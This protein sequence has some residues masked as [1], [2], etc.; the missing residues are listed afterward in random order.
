LYT[1]TADFDGEDTFTYTVED[2]TG[3]QATGTVTV[4]VL[5]LDSDRAEAVLTVNVTGVND[6]PVLG[7][8][9]GV[10]TTDKLSVAPFTKVTLSDK[11]KERSTFSESDLTDDSGVTDQIQTVTITYDSDLGAI[12]TVGLSYVA[13]GVYRVQGTPDYVVSVLRAIVFTPTENVRPPI[14]Y[15]VDIELSITDGDLAEPIKDVTTVTVLG[16][17]DAPVP[18]ADAYATEENYPIRIL[19]DAQLTSGGFNFG[20]LPG[21]FQSV[22]ANGAFVTRTPLTQT[23]SLLAND[24][25]VDVD[26]DAVVTD[27]DIVKTLEVINVHT[28]AA[29]VD[30]ITAVSALGASIKLDIRAAREETNILYDPRG[31]AILNALRAGEKV[32]D[33]FYYTVRDKHGAFGTAKVA[34]EVTGVNDVP[35]ANEDGGF[36]TGEDSSITILGSGV[37]ANDTDPDIDGER[38]DDDP[39]IVDDFPK[40]SNLGAN[41]TFEGGNITYDPSGVAV[42]EA[43]ARNEFIE[44]FITYTITDGEGGTSTST[45]SLEVEGFNDRPIAENDLLEIDENDTQSRIRATGLISNDTEIDID[46][47]VPDDDHWIIP[48]REVTTP[49]GAA[50]DVETDGSYTYDANSMFIESMIEGEVQVETFPYIVIDNFRTSS[51]P[52]SFKVLADSTDVLLP[53]LSNDDVAGSVPVA[54]LG[55]TEDLGD[56]GR[57]IIES[58]NHALRDGLLIKIQAYSGSGAYNG[59]FPITV[60]DVDHFS[61]ETPFVDDPA[62]TRGTW[63]P[64]FNITA[65][66]ETDQ[67]GVLTID[68]DAQAVLY[69]PKAGFSGTETFEYTIEDGVG[70]QDVTEVSILVLDAPLNTVL[71][72]SDDRFQIGTGES[73]VE[74]DVLA[75]DNTRPALGTQLTITEVSVGSAGGVLAIIDAG[76]ALTYTPS[77][78]SYAGTET[79]TY[80]V[81]GGGSSTTTASISIEVIDRLD[82]L[83]GSDDNFFVV[84]DSTDN[85]LD[86]AANDASL[87]SFPVSF[88][89]VSVT[90]LSNGGSATI[91]NGKVNYSPAISF[92][93]NETFDYTIRDASGGYT[94][95]TVSVQVVP[96]GDDFYAQNDQY[97]VLAG[98]PELNL[99]VLFND[100]ATGAINPADLD[101]YE[102][103]LDTQAPPEVSRVSF[104]DTA[105][106]YTAPDALV[107]PGTP[108]VEIFNYEI[109]DGTDQRREATITIVIVDEL[110][111]KPNA[112]DDNFHVEKNATNID[113]DVLL[114]DIPLPNAAWVWTI[115]SVGATDQG[116]T[117]VNNGGTS[118]TYSPAH[119]F[120]G[121]ESFD[122]TIIDAFG[123]TSTATVT[124]EVGEQL[125]EPD[126]YVVLENSAD[127]DFPVLVNDD[128]LERFPADYTISAA[129]TVDAGFTPDTRSDQGGVITQLA[130]GPNNQIFYTPPA[131]FVG[132]D[133]FTYTVIDNT[134]ATL[135]ETVT[136]EVIAEE[137]DRDFAN[138]RV[139]ITGV[140]DIPVLANVSNGATT[141]KE[142]VKPFPTVSITDVDGATTTVD[143]ADYGVQEQTVTMTY[144]TYYGTV[145]T[146]GMTQIGVGTY[147]VVGTPAEVTAVLQD[148]VFTPYENL[149][150]YIDPGVDSVDFNLSI[151]D[152]Y[153]VTPV[154]GTAT[155]TITPIDDGPTLVAELPDMKLQVNDLA[156]AVH[157]PPYFADV[158]DDVPGGQLT[159]S[160]SGNT[161]AGLFDS[162]TTDQDKQLLVIVLAEDAFGVADITVRGTDRG[163]LYVE[164]TF[165]LT[166]DGPPVI[167]LPEGQNQPLAASYISGSQSGFTRDYRQSFR[168][169]NEGLLPAQA[170]VLH[171]TELDQPVSGIQLIQAQYSS[172]ENG[173]QNNFGDDTR[174]SNGV[175]VLQP[176]TYYYTVKYDLPLEPGESVVVH[177]RYRATSVEFINIRPN[178][179]VEL[180]T[181]SPTLPLGT[182]AI[183]IDPNTGDRQITVSLEAGVEYRLEYS[184]DLVSWTP[185]ATALPVGEFDREFTVVDDGLNTDT[186]PSLVPLRFYRLVELTPPD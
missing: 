81:S 107:T 20:D 93:G 12:S 62:G 22:D 30:Q 74:I 98:S 68:T 3:S 44:D 10:S 40:T 91:V 6:A 142:S 101:I 157:L 50:L 168:V 75:N 127:N 89:I 87:P 56:A 23:V 99:P 145:A 104:T 132:V 131:D 126:Y 141:D 123:A 7:G 25:D 55:Y 52:D 70:G 48:Q 125:T 139:E 47:S 152:G 177:L 115:D 130:S 88:S 166:V 86:V 169:T 33:S 84:Q 165:R 15:D 49:L 161:N 67:E 170:F 77:S 116:G 180:T 138:F 124:I 100:G 106:Q 129:G 38:A 24:N 120:Y 137:S 58:T 4:T 36:E 85:L 175:T 53:V 39:M 14:Y 184:A 174:S 26:D 71:S 178:V 128:I 171:V 163:G 134:G 54:V 21:D 173:T 5:D 35:T 121:V 109:D 155:I 122:Y 114:N 182:S 79:F 158:D 119:G 103:G 46:H 13:D 66:G 112:L 29:R 8:T 28:L 92:T 159:W 34:I 73:A 76:K 111:T 60:V 140:N 176:A 135:V 186:H 94:T 45:I 117:A 97:I 61:I 167:D 96:A 108:I 19:A 151:D 156:R 102:L 16:I 41:L 148:V 59:V 153:V 18:V 179:R 11:D 144:D 72:A 160:V 69:T 64:W 146:P 57:V 1:P 185:W 82:Y 162:L 83:D 80:T 164:D 63:R 133:T 17:N 27:P 90:N 37:L 181:A 110:P 150:D 143:F 147:R 136:V 43:L 2:A 105:V 51:A 154:T 183:V 65:V 32:T 113:L 31:S 42:F 149:I 78:D 9:E 95:K 118:I 172:D